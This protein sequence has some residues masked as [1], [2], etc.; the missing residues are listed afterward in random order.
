MTAIAGFN[1]YAAAAGTGG[2]S[3]HEGLMDI[4]TNISPTDTPMFS[5]FAKKDVNVTM[6]EWL[7][8]SL[9][10]ATKENAAI[11]GAD[12]S[13]SVPSARTR[14][15][16]YT[17]IFTKTV[18]VTRTQRKVNVAAIDD[19]FNYEVE[20]AMKEIAN[21]IEEAIVNGTAN[22]GASGTAREMKGVLSFI[23]TNA[24]TGTGTGDEALTEAMY[25]NLL[26]TVYTAGGNPDVTY[27]NG[28]QKRKID[29]FSTPNT[30]Y[31]DGADGKLSA[32]VGV[33]QSSF[34]I[35]KI[36]LD[37]HMSTSQVACLEKNKWQV[38]VLDPVHY[39]DVAKVGDADRGAIVGELTLISLNEAASG[40]I[41]GLSTS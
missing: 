22:A 23:S 32:Y 34:G 35:Q 20:K 25:N 9:A 19:E 7:T 1:T 41:T 38:G 3:N 26:Q 37:R 40:K 29:A 14:V 27:V 39:V 30:R 12:F 36:V 10:T 21:D 15:S 17:Q 16:N 2:S 11:E 8:D 4:L 31:Q 24:E 13:F 28:W 5:E 6:P 18:E 33:Y